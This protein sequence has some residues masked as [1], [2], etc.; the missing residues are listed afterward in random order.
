MVIKFGDLKVSDGRVTEIV[1]RGRK[2]F[3][4]LQDW[5]ERSTAVTFEDVIGFE[6]IG[7]IDDDLS[8]AEESTDD[9]LIQQ[10]C[11]QANVSIE[12]YRCFSLFSSWTD[13]PLL[14]IVAQRCQ[15]E[16]GSGSEALSQEP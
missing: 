4:C 7:A 11:R 9:P 15:L 12:G 5:K 3:L 10:V 6:G 1:I 8:H 13:K 16:P 2:L 14:R